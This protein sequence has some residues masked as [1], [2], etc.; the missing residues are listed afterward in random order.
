[1]KRRCGLSHRGSCHFNYLN[2]IALFASYGKLFNRASTSFSSFACQN[3]REIRNIS[4]NLSVLYD[5]YSSR[6]I[7]K[8][9]TIHFKSHTR[10]VKK[11][12]NTWRKS[13]KELY[14]YSEPSREVRSRG[15]RKYLNKRD[16]N[17][18]FEVCI[19]LSVQI[20]FVP[21]W[22]WIVWHTPYL[23]SLNSFFIYTDT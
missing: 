11:K 4:K 3:E 12:K 16:Q 7:K 22:P 15:S 9:S 20:T 14:T 23:H 6:I 8:K 13:V 21:L 1:M 17:V 19:L 10:L 5:R 2:A 18:V